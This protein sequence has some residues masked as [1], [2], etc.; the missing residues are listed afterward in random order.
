MNP[1]TLLGFK[2][3]LEEVSQKWTPEDSNLDRWWEATLVAFLRRSRPL[4]WLE[5]ESNGLFAWELAIE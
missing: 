5:A 1:R 2:F 4:Y 3:V